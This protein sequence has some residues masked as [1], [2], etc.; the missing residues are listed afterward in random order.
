MAQLQ[1]ILSGSSSER[2]IR[3]VSPE[4]TAGTLLHSESQRSLDSLSFQSSRTSRD[5]SHPSFDGA[6]G[7]PLR[8]RGSSSRASKLVFKTADA[9][10]EAQVSARISRRLETLGSLASVSKDS[11]IL[12]EGWDSKETSTAMEA[13]L[14]RP[15]SGASRS[16]GTPNMR[17]SLLT[18]RVSSLSFMDA[19]H[20]PTRQ[21]DRVSLHSEHSDRC[22]DSSPDLPRLP[23]KQ[24]S[25]FRKTNVPR[26]SR[27][28]P[29]PEDPT[30][31]PV[32]E[33]SVDENEQ[34]QASAKDKKGGIRWKL[35]AASGQK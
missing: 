20:D 32:P 15:R 23:K 30:R 31:Q 5:C 22:D 11:T 8:A 1:R 7:R 13:K 2:T 14:A 33:K 6:H 18:K 21:G 35:A 34:A 4:S 9:E 12:M 26:K 3:Q 19:S 27:G 24:P 10:L 25:A 28:F 17:Q 16:Q 29:P